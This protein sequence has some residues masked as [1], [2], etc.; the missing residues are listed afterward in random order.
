M[1]LKIL[2]YVL[3][4]FIFI[5][6]NC[7][8]KPSLNENAQLLKSLLPENNEVS[9]WKLSSPLRFFQPENLWELINGAAEG[10]L[11]YGLKEMVIS[12]F[13]NEDTKKEMVIEIYQ[14]EDNTN[15][16]GIYS[17]ERFPDNKFINIGTQG[18][19]DNMVL[20]FWKDRYYIKLSGFESSP[21]YNKSLRDMAEVTSDKVSVDKGMPIFLSYFP[22]KGLIE[23]SEKFISKDFLGHGFLMNGYMA[24]Y[25]IEDKEVKFF[26]IDN[27]NGE[28]S[29]SSYEKYKEFINSTGKIVSSIDKIGDEGFIGEDRYY[30]IITVLKKG[31]IILGALGVDNKT[32]GLDLIK[33]SLSKIG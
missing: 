31:N 11:V 26:L 6:T 27:K 8:K 21:E 23:N 24:D 32:V 30:G 1:L 12:E 25:N 28:A 9:G 10:Y 7:E 20:N 19:E 18:Y 14:M 15:G 4:F 13:I 16:F 33:E 3:I 2:K 29:K 5:S 22:Q 17:A